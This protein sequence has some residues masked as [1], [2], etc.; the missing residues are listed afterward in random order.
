MT[1]RLCIWTRITFALTILWCSLA[2]AAEPWP[3]TSFEVFIG[4][5]KVTNSIGGRAIQQATEDWIDADEAVPL[6]RSPRDLAKAVAEIELVLS[7]SAREL[8]RMGFRAPTLEPLIKREDGSL[9]YR[10]YINDV[11]GHAPAWYSTAHDCSDLSRPY[12]AINGLSLIPSGLD[13]K[14]YQDIP[15]ELFHAVQRSYAVVQDNCH[16]GDWIIEGTAQAL[17]A[18]LAAWSR[19][20]KSYPNRDGIWRRDRWGTRNY[21]LP[22]WRP[23]DNDD[24]YQVVRNDAYGTSSFWRYL[25]EHVALSGG[26]GL[27]VVKP[28]YRFLRDWLDV[29]LPGPPGPASEMQWL[30]ARLRTDGRFRLGLARI[31]PNF[32]TTF[33]SYVPGRFKSGGDKPIVAQDYWLQTLFPSDSCPDVTLNGPQSE[34]KGTLAISKNS[35]I[36]LRL[37]LGYTKPVDLHIEVSG[38]PPD[39]LR[40]LSVGTARGR[41]VARPLLKGLGGVSSASFVIHIDDPAPEV[42]WPLIFSNVSSQ[43]E[44]SELIN[45]TVRI[46]PASFTHSMLP[47]PAKQP[48]RPKRAPNGGS[49]ATSGEESI[50]L[51]TQARS[52]GEELDRGLD[53]MN[54]QLA[55]SG[56]TASK[57]DAPPCKDA[58]VLQ[59]CGPSTRI[60]LVTVPGVLS[61]VAQ[62]TGRGGV[63]GQ[64]MSML[65]GVAEV[66]P[67][68]VAD[69]YKKAMER[70]DE[71]D[72]SFVNIDIPL[73]DYGYTGTFDNALI[74]V[75]KKDGGQVESIGPLDIQPGPGQLFALSGSVT[76]EEF[77]TAVMRG[78]FS[79]A[80]VDRDDIA[81]MG[82]D[83]SLPVRDNISGRFQIAVPWVEDGRVSRETPEDIEIEVT[84]DVTAISPDLDVWLE[85]AAAERDPTGGGT[86]SGGSLP[87]CYCACNAIET[88]AE[89]CGEHC[90]ATFAACKGQQATSETLAA[91][92]YQPKRVDA[93][94]AKAD[95]EPWLPGVPDAQSW[96]NEAAAMRLLDAIE[97]RQ[98]VGEWIEAAYSQVDWRASESRQSTTS[99]RLMFQDLDSYDSRNLPADELQMNALAFSALQAR[100]IK[101]VSGLGNIAFLADLGESTS[102]TVLTGIYGKAWGSDDFG[103]ELV[104]TYSLAQPSLAHDIRGQRLTE[105]AR[106]QVGQLLATAHRRP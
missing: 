83:G 61:S 16:L 85:S 90:G 8:Q 68:E 63:F 2:N 79:A 22:L 101:Q 73:I 45:A 49:G 57:P 48:S 67:T 100:S 36:C 17:G 14:T 52:V 27:P 77:S 30:E 60:S 34:Y 91:L 42:P 58:F 94:A 35:A 75:S 87:G 80:L 38:A 88:I 24:R 33:A 13:N 12:L 82:D 44:Y 89:A 47:A 23:D 98:V 102:L 15:H 26:A 50:N 69:R 56:T 43:P 99:L 92:A 72:G 74:T 66:G 41:I 20:R 19:F 95:G 59:V 5:P 9:A 11:P 46:V 78:T 4:K 81:G 37:V 7:D 70:A 40:A 86:S 71:Y 55:D 32:I 84:R 97:V 62:A 21:E 54:P 96:L 25:G 65:S 1:K 31:Y 64:F 106:Q 105:L 29:G 104:V 28:D 10:V 6:T 93:T 53:D 39:R 3:T 103:T 76:I 18:D 51:Q